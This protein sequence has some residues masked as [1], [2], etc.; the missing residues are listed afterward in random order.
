MRC[1]WWAEGRVTD[2]AASGACGRAVN[3]WPLFTTLK[4]RRV[5]ISTDGS[6]YRHPHAATLAWV[7]KAIKGVELVF[8]HDN[9]YSQP[10]AA[11]AKQPDAKFSVRV[12][13]PGGVNID[14]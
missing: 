2:P 7:I 3:G 14:L 10:W 6:A 11:S 4:P 5:L 1:L 8:N 13:G 12:G 9:A